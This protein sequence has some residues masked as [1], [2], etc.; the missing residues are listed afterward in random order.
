MDGWNMFGILAFF[1]DGLFS[2]ATTLVS[3]RV[4]VCYYDMHLE[5]IQHYIYTHSLCTQSSF[6]ET[7]THYGFW[8]MNVIITSLFR[9]QLQV[10]TPRIVDLFFHSFGL[11]KKNITLYRIEFPT[12]STL[13]TWVLSD[14][15]CWWQDVC[16][17]VKPAPDSSSHGPHLLR[18]LMAWSHQR[19]LNYMQFWGISDIIYD[20]GVVS[21][22]L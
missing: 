13:F 19:R 12:N 6:R 21:W 4:L 1:W 3:G 14:L 10:S 15:I 17:D 11:P 5:I 22:E 9:Y 8:V 7:G 20:N 16:F 18:T 2:G